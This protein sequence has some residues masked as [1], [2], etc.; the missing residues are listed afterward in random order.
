VTGAGGCAH[1]R[2]HDDLSAMHEDFHSEPHSRAEHRRFHEDLEDYHHDMH[3][4][5]YFDGQ[6]Y[7]NDSYYRSRYY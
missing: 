3:D 7:G 1:Q 4:R 6:G 2:F 5:G